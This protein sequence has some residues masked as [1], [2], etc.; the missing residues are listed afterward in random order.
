MKK[1]FLLA[2][3]M[4]LVVGFVVA[5]TSGARDNGLEIDENGV[6]I[7]FPKNI[8]EQDINED[9]KFNIQE[10]GIN[11]EPFLTPEE[12]Q[13]GV[14]K[15]RDGD[16]WI[17]QKFLFD[18]GMDGDNEIYSINID[19][20]GLTKITN[21]GY[22]DNCASWNHNGSYI[23][24]QSYRSNNRDIYKIKSDGSSE[25]RLTTHSDSDYCPDWNHD[26]SKVVFGTQR[27]PTYSTDL[28]TMNSDGSNKQWFVYSNWP[29]EAHPNWSP[30]GSKIAYIS[31]EGEYNPY[32]VYYGPYP[33]GSQVLVVDT[34]G[35]GDR[36]P[37]WNP[38][39]SKIV[40]EYNTDIYVINVDGTNFTQLT[41]NWSDRHPSWS[42]DGSKIGFLSD[43]TGGSEIFM[44]DTDGTNITQVTNI[45]TGIDRPD[46]G[47]ILVPWTYDLSI[48]TTDINLP[49]EIHEGET[50]DVEITVHNNGN[51]PI[52]NA[53]IYFYIDDV[54]KQ[55]NSNAD[56]AAESSTVVSFSWTVEAGSHTLKAKADPYNDIEEENEN[57]NQG[58]EVVGAED[59]QYEILVIPLNWQGTQQD[60]EDA[61]NTQ[62]DFFL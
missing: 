50:V 5:A 21:N 6:T 17:T 36:W 22:D 62:L 14:K 23:V 28:Y 19:G 39:S 40:F 12:I 33:G 45:S 44:M 31:W 41:S 13:S 58:E 55:S 32:N 43:R 48:S 26:G 42:P 37:N 27:A 29:G 60:F 4:L 16:Y 15:T 9:F 11:A 52:E 20:S 61:V 1:L 8:P 38:N 18:S 7:K 51:A 49:S 56:I 10:T 34:D 54:L 53:L 57:N 46:W 47:L 24:F 25:Q 3:L 59:Y 35:S 30:D 2:I